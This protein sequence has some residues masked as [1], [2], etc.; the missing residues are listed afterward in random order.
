MHCLW[1]LPANDSYF[2]GRWLTV[3][4]TF[5][6]TLP[7]DRGIWQGRFW[8]HT[9]RDERDFAAHVDDVHFNPVKHGL[10]THPA[11]WLYSTFQ[12]AVAKGFYPASWSGNPLEPNRKGERT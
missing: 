3:T 1:T 2:P 5:S 8:G 10:A 9:I 6:R 11:E 4:K 12:R 7:A